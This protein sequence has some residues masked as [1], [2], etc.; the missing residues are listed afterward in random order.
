MFKNAGD[1][2]SSALLQHKPLT[3]SCCITY[4]NQTVSVVT[5]SFCITYVNQTV[6]VVTCSCCITYV[7]QTVYVVTCSCC[8][9][10]DDEWVESVKCMKEISFCHSQ[11][12]TITTLN[13]AMSIKQFLL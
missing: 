1:N 13:L 11:H 2:T 5:C 4:I 9:E 10:T 6:Y 12:S 8:I 7:N 3:C